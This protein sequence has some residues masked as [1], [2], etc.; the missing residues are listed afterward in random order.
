MIH[1]KNESNTEDYSAK[2]TSSNMMIYNM[3]THLKVFSLN[4]C[5][6]KILF[7][8]SNTSLARHIKGMTY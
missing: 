3:K 8:L 6:R 2:T 4:K 7:M 1:R 5:N